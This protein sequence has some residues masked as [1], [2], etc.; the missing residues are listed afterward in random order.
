MSCSNVNKEQIVKEMKESINKLK[1]ENDHLNQDL[2]TKK[3][4]SNLH[5]CSLKRGCAC[6][7]C[8]IH[9]LKLKK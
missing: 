6:K 8:Q 2:K 1:Q 4:G 7:K 3:S 5:K 9:N